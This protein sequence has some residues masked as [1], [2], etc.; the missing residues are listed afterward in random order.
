MNTQHGQQILSQ[1]PC[2]KTCSRV[3]VFECDA[4]NKSSHY[5]VF[6]TM[7]R[8]QHFGGSQH[9]NH[10]K[11]TFQSVYSSNYVFIDIPLVFLNATFGYEIVAPVSIL[12]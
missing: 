7:G 1:C 11:Y 5:H 10:I 4:G 9:W 6:F 3:M 2:G 8:V 12:E